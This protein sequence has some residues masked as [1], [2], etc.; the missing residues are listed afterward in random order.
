MLEAHCFRRSKKETKLSNVSS[1]DS[2]LS[3][4]SFMPFALLE[5]LLEFLFAFFTSWFP[6]HQGHHTCDGDVVNSEYVVS[7]MT[8]LQSLLYSLPVHITLIGSL[9]RRSNPIGFWLVCISTGGGVD[10]FT[11][12]TRDLSLVRPSVPFLRRN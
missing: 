10:R 2:F 9:F 3:W 8:L 12:P 5:G 7:G 11:P 6:R 1:C 4:T